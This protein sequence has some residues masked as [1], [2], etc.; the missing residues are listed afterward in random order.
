MAVLAE[1]DGGGEDH[2]VV[3]ASDE[4]DA[5]AGGLVQYTAG[6]NGHRAQGQVTTYNLTK[7]PPPPKAADDSIGSV[8]W[9]EAMLSETEKMVRRDQSKRPP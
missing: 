3:I 7:P 9:V 1:A 2:A 5:P 4:K 8:K 6:V